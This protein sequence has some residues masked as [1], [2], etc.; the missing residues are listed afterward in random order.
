MS[1]FRAQYE[2]DLQD[3]GKATDILRQVHRTTETKQ[4]PE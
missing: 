3:V 2:K 4:K 1:V